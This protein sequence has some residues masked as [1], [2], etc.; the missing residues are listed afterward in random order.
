MRS[1]SHFRPSREF[2][3]ELLAEE[4]WGTSLA[5]QRGEKRAREA[6]ADW[7]RRRRRGEGGEWPKH[8]GVCKLEE[9]SG[10]SS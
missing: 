1:S 6:G 4:I 2:Q 9:A 10:F 7:K 5:H 3:A 8:S